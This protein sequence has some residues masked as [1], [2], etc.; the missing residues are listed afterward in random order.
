M[1]LRVLKVG[2]GSK[3]CVSHL[4]MLINVNVYRVRVFLGDILADIFIL[5]RV[6]GNVSGKF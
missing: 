1:N 5:S 6:L 4:D 3:F 2:H